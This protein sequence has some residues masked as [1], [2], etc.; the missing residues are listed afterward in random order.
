MT[1]A[2]VF[3]GQGRSVKTKGLPNTKIFRLENKVVKGTLKKLGRV[4]NSKIKPLMTYAFVS[5]G[6]T[7]F[8][9]CPKQCIV[10]TAMFCWSGPN[11][12]G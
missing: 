3:V 5:V 10:N 4:S 9:S 6:Q 1:L 7:L 2:F 8:L 12:P 11:K